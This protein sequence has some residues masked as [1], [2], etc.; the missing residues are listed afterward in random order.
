MK[1][2]RDRLSKFSWPWEVPQLKRDALNQIDLLQDALRRTVREAN[3][4]EARADKM[5]SEADSLRGKFVAECGKSLDLA[6]QVDVLM[7]EAVHRERL[8]AQQMKGA[9]AGCA[10]LEERCAGLLAGPNGDQSKETVMAKKAPPP[11]P[12]PV[13]KGKGKKGC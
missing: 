8:H 9:L 5:A 13:G 10:I 6:K 7:L 4:H 1:S 12:M 11:A 3:R 2:L